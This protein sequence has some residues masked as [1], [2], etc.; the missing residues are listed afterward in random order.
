[1]S[2]YAVILA[3]LVFI[4]LLTLPFFGNTVAGLWSSFNS[5]FSG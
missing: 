4:V 3:L 2:E 1:M 5:A